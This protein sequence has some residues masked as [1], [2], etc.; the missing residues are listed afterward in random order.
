MVQYDFQLRPSERNSW[1]E[2]N[3]LYGSVVLGSLIGRER[4]PWIEQL[5]NRLAIVDCRI[6]FQSESTD[7]WS[8]QQFP[9]GDLELLAVRRYQLVWWRFRRVQRSRERIDRLPSGQPGNSDYRL[10]TLKPLWRRCWLVE[11]ICNR[12]RSCAASLSM[13]L[14]WC[15]HRR[16]H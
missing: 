5:G 10:A 3:C 7:G 15:E 6:S 12:R 11:I 1:I 16:R 9:L 13:A 14:R 8:E 4:L 2:A